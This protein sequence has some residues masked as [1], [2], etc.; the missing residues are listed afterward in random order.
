MTLRSISCSFAAQSDRHFPQMFSDRPE[1]QSHAV[2]RSGAADG[3]RPR[4][5]A[6]AWLPS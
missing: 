6:D 3:L 5:A 4:G 1:M 2:A